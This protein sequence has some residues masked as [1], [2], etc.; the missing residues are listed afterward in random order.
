MMT[1]PYEWKIIECSNLLEVTHRV[2]VISGCCCHPAN[3]FFGPCGPKGVN[4]LVWLFWKLTVFKGATGAGVLRDRT[5]V[6]ADSTPYREYLGL[7][8]SVFEHFSRELFTNFTAGFHWFI[9]PFL[10]HFQ[11]L[12][13]QIIFKL[14]KLTVKHSISQIHVV[15]VQ[16]IHTIMRYL[17]SGL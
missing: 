10:W 9:F 14:K 2:Y 7:S 5:A 13:H 8:V 16:I 15:I 12:L 1:S 17:L 4:W 11:I 6:I 3:S